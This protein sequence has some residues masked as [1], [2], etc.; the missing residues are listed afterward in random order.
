MAQ[1]STRFG[2]MKR[3]GKIE[4]GLSPI[5]SHFCEG[6]IL[7]QKNLSIAVIPIVCSLFSACTSQQV[8][9]AGQEY[10]RN[11]CLHIPDK[12][13]SDKCLSKMNSSY[14]DYKRE[15]DI[16]KMDNGG[17]DTGG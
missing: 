2:C 7:I 8:Y 15:K 6:A 17:S 11:Q 16:G 3:L 5:N 14:D 4:R 9:G 12:T 10:Q 13:E 1:T